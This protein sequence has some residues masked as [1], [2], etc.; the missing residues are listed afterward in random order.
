MG[1]QLLGVSLW[2]FMCLQMITVHSLET[3]VMDSGL[4]GTNGQPISGPISVAQERG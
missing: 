2:A 3:W 4:A 1:L